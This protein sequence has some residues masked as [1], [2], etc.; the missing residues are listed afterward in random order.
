MS[1]IYKLKITRLL[2]APREKAFNAWAR[3]ESLKCFL[4][5]DAS[6]TV[7]RLEADVRVGGKFRYTLQGPDGKSCTAYGVYKTVN[8]GEK[9]SF[10]W[11]WE[12]DGRHEA[13]ETLVT[14]E[15]LKKGAGAELVFT[16]DLFS[17]EAE[18]DDHLGGWTGCIEIFDEFITNNLQGEL[19]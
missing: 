1:S 19:P 3:P 7:P 2:D 11:K 6:F 13:D 5:P 15:F 16:H 12:R 18:R 17:T 14:I 4:K 9:L 10:T 8:S